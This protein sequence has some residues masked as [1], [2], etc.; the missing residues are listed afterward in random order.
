M[1]AIDLTSADPLQNAQRAAWLVAN[2]YQ[3]VGKDSDEAAEVLAAVTGEGETE[4][5]SEDQPRHP[6]TGQFTAKG[7]TMDNATISRLEKAM[8]NPALSA[9]G[10]A[11]A[12]EQV[13][14]ARLS[15]FH[16]AKSAAQAALNG[17]ATP[18]AAG[19]IDSGKS[20]VAGSVTQGLRDQPADSS[21]RLGGATTADIPIED[22]V[23]DNPPAPV[24]TDG[25]GIVQPQAIKQLEKE[26]R[27]AKHPVERARIG[28][29]LTLAR[30]SLFHAVKGMAALTGNGGDVIPAV[31]GRAAANDVGAVGRDVSPEFLAKSRERPGFRAVLALRGLARR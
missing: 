1:T 16:L 5:E 30:L 15:R 14:L 26:F 7:A 29:Q 10:R 21:L 4:D 28:E 18:Q 17:T 13:T 8:N 3:P 2:G 24:S 11:Q 27:K 22:K 31:T 23:R 12:A 20:G 9:D 25:A 6:V 19:H